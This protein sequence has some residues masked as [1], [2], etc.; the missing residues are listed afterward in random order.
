M[1]WWW[2]TPCSG[3]IQQRGERNILDTP[4]KKH[5]STQHLIQILTHIW[6][7][8]RKTI[9]AGIKQ[10]TYG[11][12]EKSLKTYNV[13]VTHC[14]GSCHVHPWKPTWLWKTSFSIGNTFSFMVDFPAS[15]VSFQGGC[16]ATWQFSK[17]PYPFGPAILAARLWA[18]QVMAD[19]FAEVV[20]T[21]ARFLYHG[22]HVELVR[23]DNCNPTTR[24]AVRHFLT[25]K[26]WMSPASA[27]PGRGGH[28]SAS[29]AQARRRLSTGA[30]LVVKFISTSG[31]MSFMWW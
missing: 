13:N 2:S 29:R 27:A 6:G 17:A 24:S 1:R 21:T 8:T 31:I 14:L 10:L 25:S 15:H 28:V 23:T 11:N 18:K 22:F 26:F 16:L 30:A 19:L 3:S 9:F 5:I 7:V 20:T 4:K 12:L